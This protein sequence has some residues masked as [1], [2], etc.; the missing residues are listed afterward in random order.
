MNR[1][2]LWVCLVGICLVTAGCQ[3]RNYSGPQRYPLSGK[4]TVDGEPVDEGNIAFTDPSGGTGLR[5]SGG[6]IKDGRFSVS[7][8]KG[9]TAGKYRVRINWLK[10][11]GKKYRAPET[12]D[13]VWYDQRKE[14]LPER[15]RGPKSELS[16][17]VPSP[18]NTYNFDLKLK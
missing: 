12:S 5:E 1:N 8:E 3:R 4:V 6:E 10:K 15:F 18:N 2:V 9:P 11:T 17:E 14:A 16:A 7:E 13:E